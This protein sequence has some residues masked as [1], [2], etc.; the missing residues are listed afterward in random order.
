MSMMRA[1]TVASDCCMS[2]MRTV[3]KRWP[4]ATSTSR[5]RPARM[6]EK[7]ATTRLRRV[8]SRMMAI[9]DTSGA[10]SLLANCSCCWSERR[11]ACSCSC[12][13][14]IVSQAS[15][16]GRTCSRQ[17]M[18]SLHALSKIESY[19]FE[20]ASLVRNCSSSGT[21]ARTRLCARAG[22]SVRAAAA[23]TFSSSSSA[24]IFSESISG[25]WMTATTAGM[26]WRSSTPHC[27]AV[28]PW[29]PGGRRR[30]WKMSGT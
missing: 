30:T 17:V 15:A 5:R 8:P 28:R 7:R 11:V 3:S 9:S 6:A 10:R 25:A 29:P 24:V 19:S 18:K 4:T 16:A 13:A 22:G 1:T 27:S 20:Q 21:Q 2:V 26:Q 14:E 23:T 12:S